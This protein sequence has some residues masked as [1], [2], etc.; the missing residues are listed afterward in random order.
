MDV[1]ALAQT[2]LSSRTAATYSDAQVS[3]LKK[4]M[5]TQEAAATKLLETMSLPLATEGSLGRNVNTYA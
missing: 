4:T 2:I 3:I 1:A 5:D